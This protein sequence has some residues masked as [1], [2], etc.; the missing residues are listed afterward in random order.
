MTKSFDDE[1]ITIAN[2]M[3][4]ALYT[5]FDLK[6]ASLFLR[7]TGKELQN[8]ILHG[9]LNYI[10]SNQIEF[11]G[12]QL[13]EYLINQTTNNNITN[14][15]QNNTIPKTD[16]I[17]RIKELIDMVGLS[18]T[19]IWRMEG[20]GSFPKRVSLGTNSVGWKLSEINEW[21]SNK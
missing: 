8:L 5:R 12:Y 6:E 7:T 20:Y 3:G 10:K 17:I 14:N 19:T 18:R 15:S 13:I 2:D 16:R 4:I 9:Q 11:F 1:F 21:L